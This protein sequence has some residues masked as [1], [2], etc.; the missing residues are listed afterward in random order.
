V[1]GVS[2][3]DFVLALKATPVLTEFAELMSNMNSDNTECAITGAM[4]GNALGLHRITHSLY[5]MPL[6]WGLAV[7]GAN[8]DTWNALPQDLKALLKAELPRLE[9]D[10]WSASE[11]E[12]GNGVA[13]NTGAAACVRGSKG[14]MVEVRPSAADE[15][16]T[17][18]IFAKEVLAPWVRRCG[19]RCAQI[20]EQTIGPAVGIKGPVRQ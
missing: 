11:R 17:R 12:T 19:A 8:R 9:A 4:S 13:C 14:A 18:E 6:S 7:F 1:S 5:T 2:Q 20:W 10:V 16:R 15:R 3:A